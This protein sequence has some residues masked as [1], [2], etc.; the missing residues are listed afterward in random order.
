MILRCA[1]FLF[2]MVAFG[3]AQEQSAEAN[4]AVFEL[5]PRPDG[6]VSDPGQWLSPPVKEAWNR[7]L[8]LWK[9]NDGVDLFVAILPSLQGTP[10]DHVA[11]EIGQTWG[12]KEM[13]GVVLFVPGTEGPTLYWGGEIND[14]IAQDPRSR[15]S[16]IRGMERRVRSEMSDEEK[17]SSAIDELSTT[18][19]VIHAQW[20][21]SRLIRQKFDETIFKKATQRKF[22]HR[23]TLVAI[24]ALSL[25][26]L[27]L[28]TW[29]ILTWRKHKKSYRFPVISPQ[30]RFG[31]NHAGGSGAV[32]TLITKRNRL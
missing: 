26:A 11:R 4:K 22:S 25:V 18:M 23:V 32:L 19:R 15:K 14:Q 2:A 28:V 31:A 7:Q 29:A 13:H 27:T 5:P 8:D 10:A 21:Q 9:K 20:K 16:M 1:I 3:L 30:R 6:H 24:V 17:L 12:Q